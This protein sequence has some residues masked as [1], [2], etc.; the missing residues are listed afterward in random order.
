[1]ALCEFKAHLSLCSQGF[2]VSP[3][4]QKTNPQSERSASPC[5]SAEL[6]RTHLILT[7]V[8]LSLML[9][10]ESRSSEIPFRFP[11]FS[12][13]FDPLLPHFGLW[14]WQELV[15]LVYHKTIRHPEDDGHRVRRDGT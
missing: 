9:Q 4:V 13:P 15:T 8:F 5:S 10:S 2:I 3:S 14:G 7:K 6:L 1:M 11:S 12:V